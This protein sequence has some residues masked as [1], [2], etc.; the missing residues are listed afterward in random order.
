MS[1]C[2]LFIFVYFLEIRRD[3]LSVLL[4]IMKIIGHK[5]SRSEIAAGY[6]LITDRI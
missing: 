3:W 1:I 4:L 6:E 5:K 2:P